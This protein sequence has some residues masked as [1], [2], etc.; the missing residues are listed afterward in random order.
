MFSKG[1]I[2]FFL[3]VLKFRPKKSSKYSFCS[4][5]NLLFRIICNFASFWPRAVDFVEDVFLSKLLWV[6]ESA[7]RV[8]RSSPKFRSFRIAQYFAQC[9]P[10]FHTYDVANFAAFRSTVRWGPV[11]N[12]RSEN[13]NP[14]FSQ[15]LQ[16][17]VLGRALCGVLDPDSWWY[18]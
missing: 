3:E 11:A 8:T 18:K 1:V 14:V 4:Y 9:F 16:G 7:I 13:G 15:E 2:Y 5:L 12:L 17:G 6:Q 10:L